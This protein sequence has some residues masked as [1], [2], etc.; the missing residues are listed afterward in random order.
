[1]CSK[2]RP[3]EDYFKQEVKRIDAFYKGKKVIASCI[4]IEQVEVARAYYRLFRS[5]Y[6]L[7]PNA[8]NQLW[9]LH[10][11]LLDKRNEMYKALAH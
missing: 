11:M 4:T 1:M 10:T 7:N 2:N 9:I 6:I 5:K 3:T 8:L